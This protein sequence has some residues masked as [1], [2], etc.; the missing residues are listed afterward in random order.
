MTG[1]D[2]MLPFL[3]LYISED[4][5]SVLTLITEGV[6][7]VL[8]KGNKYCVMTCGFRSNWIQSIIEDPPEGGIQFLAVLLETFE[9]FELNIPGIQPLINALAEDVPVFKV[10]RSG[11]CCTLQRLERASGTFPTTPM[12]CR[13]D[14]LVATMEELLEIAPFPTA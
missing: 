12:V 10:S 13:D 9:G 11:N 4:K 3:G 1:R 8:M 2:P 6:S 7:R 5:P 14:E